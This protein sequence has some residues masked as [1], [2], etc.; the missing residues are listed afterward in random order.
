MSAARRRTSRS[1]LS[2]HRFGSSSLQETT[3]HK[4]PL[5]IRIGWVW[6]LAVTPAQ[7][8]GRCRKE[9]E[10]RREASSPTRR[11]PLSDKN[12]VIPEDA[13]EVEYSEGRDWTGY[14]FGKHV[15]RPGSI[16][17]LTYQRSHLTLIAKEACKTCQS[18][19][20]ASGG[21]KTPSEA[22]KL[23]ALANTSLQLP[24]KLL[25]VRPRRAHSGV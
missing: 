9:E 7:A 16:L 19:R 21:Q 2:S 20:V 22:T 5:R 24:L 4:R 10:G 1:K 18:R 8:Q 6:T 23:C 13:F 15:G 17:G 12:A 11:R 25:A 3:R 14:I